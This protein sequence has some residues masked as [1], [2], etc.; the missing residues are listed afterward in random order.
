MMQYKLIPAERGKFV[1]LN[2]DPCKRHMP[3]PM[4]ILDIYTKPQT[5]SMQRFDIEV[6]GN[7]CYV[8]DGV[9]VHNSPETT[10]GGRALKFYSSVR[11]D[12]RRIQSIKQGGEVV[13]NRTRVKIKK[14]KVAPPF[15]EAEFD[16]MFYENGISKPGEIVDL[17]TDIG[18][19]EKRGA[20]YRYNDN[21]LGQGRE[22]TKQYL[23][24]NPEVSDD[25]ENKI[26]EHFGL[27]TLDGRTPDNGGAP[28]PI[29]KASSGDDDSD[30]GSDDD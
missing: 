5:R 20:F 13:G 4:E 25:L 22:N 19:I 26:R 29:G 10:S 14:N 16:I 24:E 17:G 12:I 2:I 6:E 23:V 3:V 18:V 21:L 15:R 7:H 1:E 27:P 11:I 8:V 30:A 28:K 9:V